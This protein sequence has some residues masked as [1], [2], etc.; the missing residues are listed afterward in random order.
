M[1]SGSCGRQLGFTLIE[2]LV[3]M[4]VFGIGILGFLALQTATI[5]T[6]VHDQFM[7]TATDLSISK[8]NQLMLTESSARTSGEGE[9]TSNGMQYTQNWN[10]GSDANGLTTLAVTTSWNQ[11]D[12]ADQVTLST[13][14]P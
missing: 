6:R 7:T 1:G 11:K 10:V 3:A 5:T 4:A 12:E 14:L 2:V 13:V 8:L 9:V